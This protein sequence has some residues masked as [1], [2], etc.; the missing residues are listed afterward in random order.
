MNHLLRIQETNFLRSFALYYNIFHRERELVRA[1]IH[2]FHGKK[3]ILHLTHN[4][5]FD[6]DYMLNMWMQQE[7]IN[8]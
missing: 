4:D 7:Q 2:S 6:Y 8:V 1:F 5:R 3:K